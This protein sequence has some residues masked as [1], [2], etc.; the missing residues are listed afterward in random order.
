MAVYGPLGLTGSGERL[1]CK[2]FPHTLWIIPTEDR[3]SHLGQGQG[4]AW[5]GLDSG[6]L[7]VCSPSGWKSAL[8]SE[9]CDSSAIR[10]LQLAPN[11]PLFCSKF[12]TA[13]WQCPTL[14]GSTSYL[15]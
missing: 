13:P 4:G 6:G 2:R 8:S 15:F 1:V 3:V 7:A 9:K 12:S 5:T 14:P 11:T 10:H